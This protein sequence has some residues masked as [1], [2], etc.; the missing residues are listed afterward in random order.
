MC[1]NTSA[2][3]MA[4]NHVQHKRTKYIDVR[5]HFLRD[6]I[7]KIHVVMKFCNTED[8]L[9]DIFTNPLSKESF[10]KNSLRLGMH[11]IT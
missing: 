2:I 6:I 8:Q 9:V 3:N 10:M 5:H 4:K 11:K 7:E 1:D